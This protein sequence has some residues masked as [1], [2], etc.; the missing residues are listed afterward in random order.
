MKAFRIPPIYCPLPLAR[1]PALDKVEAG[2]IDYMRKWRLF[3][4]DAQLQRLIATRCGEVV[5]MLYPFGGQTLLQVAADYMLWAFAYDDE[6]CDEGPASRD[7]AALIAGSSRMQ[8]AME[9]AEVLF[10]PEDRYGMA[11]RDLRLRVAEHGRP[12]HA[13]RFVMMQ[14]SYFMAEMWKAVAPKPMLNDYAIKRLYGGGGMS[15]TVFCYIVPQLDISEEELF[16]RPVIALTE[17]ADTFTTWD[18]DII[19][20]PKERA[21]SQDKQHNLIS[22]L[23][24]EYRCSDEESVVIAVR[25]RDRVQGLFSRLRDHLMQHGSP[26]LRRYADYLGYYAK[27]SLDWHRSNPR[28]LYTNGISG[29]LCMVGAEPADAPL[30]DSHDPLPIS[31]I[32]WWWQYDPARRSVL[33]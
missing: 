3:W 1:H 22:V 31:A 33:S 11:L 18:N 2:C 28:Y 12:M 32:A 21:R 19:S 9:S 29:E 25:M 5:A 15:F 30:D 26:A 16:S 7:P 8:R 23:C 24:R 14:R 20:Y 17:M 6:Y 10:D 4:T 13:E 27:G